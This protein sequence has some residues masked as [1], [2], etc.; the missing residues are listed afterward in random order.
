MIKFRWLLTVGIV[1][2][3][4]YLIITWETQKNR[5]L[6]LDQTLL[7]KTQADPSDQPK[8]KLD[9]ISQEPDSL[10]N[11]KPDSSTTPPS[12]DKKAEAAVAPEVSKS[13]EQLSSLINLVLID[14]KQSEFKQELLASKAIAQESVSLLLNKA[15]SETQKNQ[16]LDILAMQFELDPEMVLEPI[17]QFLEA[18]S[19]QDEILMGYQSELVF[20][21]LNQ[22]SSYLAWIESRWSSNYKQQL[23]YNIANFEYRE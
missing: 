6:D 8:L 17:S 9:P 15:A 10:S 7:G 22:D 4:P 16:A 3:V 5:D 1:V 11:G 2:A 20:K 18:S 21:I 19:D 13:F 12:S 23:L 14:S